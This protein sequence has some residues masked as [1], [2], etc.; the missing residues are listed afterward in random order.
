MK[1]LVVLVAAAAAALGTFGA[2]PVKADAGAN[3][4][5]VNV[6]NQALAAIPS[7]SSWS[8]RYVCVWLDPIDRSWCINFPF[9]T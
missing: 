3:A 8:P 6:A 2:S 5:L 9:P 7:P 1:R 4:S